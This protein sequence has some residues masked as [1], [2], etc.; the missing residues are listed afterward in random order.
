MSDVSVYVGLK[1]DEQDRKLNDIDYYTLE[2]RPSFP[3]RLQC[4][5][6]PYN[7]GHRILKVWGTE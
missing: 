7:F 6:M 2:V 5:A 1:D 3:L 4:L